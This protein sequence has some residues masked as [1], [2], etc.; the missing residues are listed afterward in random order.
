MRTVPGVTFT[1]SLDLPRRADGA[2]ELVLEAARQ[3]V[4]LTGGVADLGTCSRWST[5]PPTA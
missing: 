1:P 2:T 4:S 5:S 3:P